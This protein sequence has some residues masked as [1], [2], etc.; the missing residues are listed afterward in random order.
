MRPPSTTT[1]CPYT[2]LFRSRPRHRQGVAVEEGPELAQHRRHTAGVKEILDQVLAAGAHV[3]EHRSPPGELVEAVE[4][5]VDPEPADRKS[6]RL[7]S[8]HMS[9]SYA[10][11]C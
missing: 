11:F 5:E 6:T 9:I 4:L 1:M 2:T 3:R 7:N 8:S 10:V